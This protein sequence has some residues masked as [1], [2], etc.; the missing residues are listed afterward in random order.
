MKLLIAAC[1]LITLVKILLSVMGRNLTFL[2]PMHGAQGFKTPAR[3]KEGEVH[4]DVSLIKESSREEV[5]KQLE[6]LVEKSPSFSLRA[7]VEKAKKSVELALQALESKD[8][9]ALQAM[10]DPGLIRRM[11]SISSKI[12]MDPEDVNS[13]LVNGAYMFDNKAFISLQPVG[14]RIGWTFSRHLSQGDPQWYISNVAIE[15]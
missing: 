13:L 1:I 7:F 5:V 11:L 6:F 2:P 4:F 8:E 3:I 10:V 15:G 12:G 9:V 14:K